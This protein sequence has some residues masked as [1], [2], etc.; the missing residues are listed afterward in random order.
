MIYVGVALGAVAV[1]AVI[2]AVVMRRRL[3][4]NNYGIDGERGSMWRSRMG[5][6][7]NAP[8]Q[9]MSCELGEF[10]SGVHVGTTELP[11]Q[12][13]AESPHPIDGD[14]ML[15]GP[16]ETAVSLAG[17]EPAKR[18]SPLDREAASMRGAMMLSPGLTSD[19]MHHD[20][21]YFD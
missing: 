6:G 10:R 14:F 12:G 18:P 21:M 4:A 9:G 3:L 8:A 2:M 19:Q 15:D 20:T 16:F 1:L 11:A 17:A 7:T 5:H 13:S